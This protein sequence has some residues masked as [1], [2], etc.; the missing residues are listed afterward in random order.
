M[1]FIELA[2]PSFIGF[3]NY[4]RCLDFNEGNSDLI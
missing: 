1:M 2:R 4:Y 3:L